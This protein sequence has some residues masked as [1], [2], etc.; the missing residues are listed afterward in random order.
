MTI[1]FRSLYF[2]Y[3]RMNPPTRGH[4]KLIDTMLEAAKLNNNSP[5]LIA[6][7]KKRSWRTDPLPLDIKLRYLKAMYP[8]A[9]IMK[10]SLDRNTFFDWLSYI[11][12]DLSVDEIVLVGGSD[13]INMFYDLAV[14]Y[15]NRDLDN[16]AG[17]NF[18]KITCLSVK[19]E[20]DVSATNMKLA[21]LRNDFETFKSLAPS[22]LSDDE[23][24][25]LYADL[26][27]YH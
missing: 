15:N 6:V 22:K 20:V 26:A 24:A 11:Y 25:T 5:H 23:I 3:G 21:V 18:N 19:R 4:E 17:Y 9:N 16:T 1:Y 27:R 8:N 13:R 10:G 7:T 14:K 2:T 12:Q